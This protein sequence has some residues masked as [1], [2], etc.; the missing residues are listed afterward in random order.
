MGIRHILCPVDLSRT[1][2]RALR[3]AAALAGWYGSALTAFYVDA[4]PPMENAADFEDFAPAAPS[5]RTEAARSSRALQDVC[6]F[7]RRAACAPD[8]AVVVE[9]STHIEHAIVEAARRL[10][11]DLIV[12]GSH[13]RAG[14]KRRLPGSITEHVLRAAT[15]PV[16]VVPPHDDVPPSTVSFEHIVCAIDFADSP[17]AAL[18]WALSLAQVADARLSLLH[19]IDVPPELCA[20]APT[21]HDDFDELNAAIRADILSSLRA[22]VPQGAA[23]FCSV[24]T[25]TSSGAPGHAILRFASERQADLIVMAARRHRVVERCPF[26]SKTSDVVCGSTCPVLTVRR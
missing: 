20:W 16:M 18:S 4:T 9:E 6:L 3:R 7:I 11:A 12:M 25:A 23:S 13:G 2:L 22:L 10:S 17:L 24:E 14:M 8:V 5:H 21:T 26:G 1:S 15:C 19:V